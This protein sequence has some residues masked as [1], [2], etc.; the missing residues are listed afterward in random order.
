LAEQFEIETAEDDS[1][2]KEGRER[3]GNLSAELVL[4]SFAEEQHVSLRLVL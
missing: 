2:G 1:H 3:V 4:V